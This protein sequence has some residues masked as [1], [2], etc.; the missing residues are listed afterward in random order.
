MLRISN[1]RLPLGRPEAELAA[2]LCKKMNIPRGELVD[3]AVYRRSLDARKG[4]EAAWLYTLDVTV[5]R[6]GPLL[7]KGFVPTPDESYVYPSVGADLR[8]P[9]VVVG[10]GPAGMFAALLLARLGLCPLVLERG[11]AVAD[12]ART[13]EAFWSQGVLNPESNVQ[14]GEGGAGAFSDGKL[15][16]RTKDSRSRFV[17]ETLAQASGLPELLVDAKPHIGTDKLRGAV[18]AIR[19]EIES[20]G[21]EVRFGCRVEQLQMKQGR[22]TGLELATG[23]V[24]PAEAAILALGHSARDTLRSLYA[25]GL[26]MEPKPFAMGVRIEHTQEMINQVQ[27]GKWADSL[28]PADYRLAVTAQNGR[29]VY[30]FCMCPGGQVVGA[31]SQ[32]G[33]LAVNGMSYHARDG[34]NANAAL[35]VQVFPQDFGSSHPLAGMFWQEELEAA[36]FAAGGGG[37]VAPVQDLAGF[38]GTAR[39][40][41]V[42]PSYRP[43]VREVELDKLLPLFMTEALRDGLRQMGRKLPGFDD[44]GAV[45]TALESRSSSPVRLLR[46]AQGESLSCV[47]LYPAGEGAGYAGGIV[48][49]A[50]DGLRAAEAVARGQD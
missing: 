2:R 25:Q 35:L 46:N 13:V 48:S 6:E 49:A 44:G 26:A 27:Y 3:F 7:A 21:G 30:T 38:L 34:V 9:P 1:L 29:G 22:L 8:H 50:I 12:R 20:R 10:F 18:T 31:A 33:R 11:E 19:R 17:L 41:S 23:E 40:I 45:L 15:T 37:F 14:F 43:G 39:K 42:T 47:G 5:K 16:A 32:P 4:R 24:I 36:A 28:P